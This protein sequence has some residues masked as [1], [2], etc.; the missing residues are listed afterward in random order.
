MTICFLC[1]GTSYPFPVI[2]KSSKAYTVAKYNEKWFYDRWTL[3]FNILTE[4]PS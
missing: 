1:T 3:S 4:T 2:W